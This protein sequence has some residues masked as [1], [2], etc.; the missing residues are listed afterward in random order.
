MIDIKRVEPGSKEE[1][2]FL[3]LPTHLYP[4]NQI[5]QNIEEERQQIAG[6]HVLSHY[7]DF[8]AFVAYE[9]RKSSPL[10]LDF[11]S[12]YRRSLSGLF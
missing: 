9:D 2:D 1:T 4:E 10:R 12:S 6:Q 5:M 3:D 11:L 7:Y 8:K